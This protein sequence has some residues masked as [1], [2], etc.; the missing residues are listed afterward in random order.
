MEAAD[1][2]DHGIVQAIREAVLAG[3]FRRAARFNPKSAAVWNHLAE[4]H[5]QRAATLLDVA[6]H[7]LGADSSGPDA[8]GEW[9]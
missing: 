7:R 1:G 9:W 3:V 8:R 5:S 4:P 2:I 6:I